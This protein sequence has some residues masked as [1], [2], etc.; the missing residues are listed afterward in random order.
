MAAVQ[1]TLDYPSVNCRQCR[2]NLENDDAEPDCADCPVDTWDMLT[3]QLLALHDRCCPWGDLIMTAVPQAMNDLE[4]GLADRRLAR[5][6]LVE[7]HR[8]KKLYHQQRPAT[9]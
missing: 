5:R 2:Q 1:F 7:I 4:I 3:R 8:T 6:C 9:N